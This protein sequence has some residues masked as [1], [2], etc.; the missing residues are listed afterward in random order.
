MKVLF[1]TTIGARFGALS[2]MAQEDS[3]KGR[4]ACSIEVHWSKRHVKLGL[5]SNANTLLFL[6]V[7]AENL[8]KLVFPETVWRSEPICHAFQ[9]TCDMLP[10]LAEDW[11]PSSGG[12]VW[13]LEKAESVSSP[14]CDV[15]VDD[16]HTHEARVLTQLSP[17]VAMVVESVGLNMH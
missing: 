16:T 12:L 10:S 3:T 8:P 2:W 11:P 14:K 5:L 4:N 17:L 6:E 9:K 7:D 15:P 1:P 13:M